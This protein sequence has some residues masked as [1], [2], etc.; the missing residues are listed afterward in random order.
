MTHDARAEVLRGASPERSSQAPDE[1]PLGFAEIRRI[2]FPWTSDTTYLNNA[3]IGPLPERTRLVL[4]EFNRKRAAPHRL[5]DRELFAG[6]AESRRLAAELIGA[7][8]EE[9]GLTINTG[10]GLSLA[11]RALPLADGRHRSHE[12]PGISRQRVSLDD[13]QGQRDHI[14]AHPNDAGWLAGRGSATGAAPGSSR[15]GARDL[16][17]AVQQRLYR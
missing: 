8:P 15:A 11:A 3:S 9:I 2:E 1:N 17:G 6:M 7:S 5:P 10:F 4:E 12:R 16:A 14:G 13:A